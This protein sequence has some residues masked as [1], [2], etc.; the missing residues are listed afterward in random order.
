MAKPSGSPA[1]SNY[2]LPT[3]TAS[4]GSEISSPYSLP[5]LPSRLS[6][7]RPSRRVSNG[8]SIL[9]Y[10]SSVGSYAP[11]PSQPSRAT[12]EHA[13]PKG[14]APR[15][16][17]PRVPLADRHNNHQSWKLREYIKHI[18]NSKVLNVSREASAAEII[19]RAGVE[20]T[21]AFE[22]QDTVAGKLA[23]IYAALGFAPLEDLTPQQ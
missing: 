21:V 23:K 4:N 16:L 7:R 11:T 5:S 20:L 8:S 18:K 10:G 1:L 19:V 12:G 3:E 6:S 17:T 2:S 15:H 14:L 9:S 22:K 13:F